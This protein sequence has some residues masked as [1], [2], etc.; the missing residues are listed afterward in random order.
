[1]AQSVGGGHI[2]EMW[3][4]RRGTDGERRSPKEGLDG[5]MGEQPERAFV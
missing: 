5:V 1:M 4:V 2:T 3:D